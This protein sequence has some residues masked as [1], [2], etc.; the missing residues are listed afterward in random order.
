MKMD[1]LTVVHEYLDHFE[2]DVDVAALR[3]AGIVATI[4]EDTRHGLM[5]NGL[6]GPGTRG[7]DPVFRLLVRE[8]DADEARALLHRGEDSLP[9]AFR[10]GEVAAWRQSVASR[11]HGRRR[12]R[13][14]WVLAWIYGL[15]ALLVVIALIGLLAGR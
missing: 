7:T 5:G 1:G 4:E 8:E 2:A 6:L 14:R 15:F 9:A 12:A 13:R 11:G 10:D 3:A